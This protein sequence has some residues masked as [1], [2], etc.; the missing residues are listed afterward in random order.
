[1]NRRSLGIEQASR[2][3]APMFLFS[4]I[5]STS[6]SPWN[7]NK[8][9]LVPECLARIASLH[10]CLHIRLTCSDLLC[11][12]VTWCLIAD[13]GCCAEPRRSWSRCGHGSSR[14]CCCVPQG[15][16]PAGKE[17]QG[18]GQGPG[19]KQRHKSGGH[20]GAPFPDRRAGRGGPA[21][22]A[23]PEA[24]AGGSPKILKP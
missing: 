3:E 21:A 14:A 22:A 6:L 8:F 10:C 9:F 4:G 5:R 17:G 20:E 7:W 23:A 15:L 12:P 1:M 11:N 16:Q 19:S 18:F 2:S 13:S 24:L